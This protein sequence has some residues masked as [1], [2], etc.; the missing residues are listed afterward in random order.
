MAHFDNNSWLAEKNEIL[1]SLAAYHRRWNRTLVERAFDFSVQIHQ[2]QY[3]QSGEPYIT[4][5]IQVAKIMIELRTDYSAVAAALLHDVVE[6]G[7]VTIEELKERFG[8][9][10]ALLVD[11]VTKISGIEFQSS[12]E[13]QVES[14]RKMLLSMLKDLR[15]ILI[16]FA[17]RLHNMRTI[18]GKPLKSR[19]KV[20]RETRD[21]YAPLATR[22]GIAKIAREMDNL[23]LKVLDPVA[24]EEISYRISKTVER[25]NEILSEIIEPI[26][27]ELTRMGLHSDVQGRVKS[28]A[29]IYNK[30]HKQKKSFDEIYD[31]LAIR[32]IVNQ[33]SECYRVLGVVHDI[34]KPVTDHFSDYIALPKTNLYQS[35]H[36]KVRD[37]KNR[38]VEI[39]I[40]T[41]EMHNIAEIGIAAHWRYKA[42]H[43]QP[44]SLDEQFKWIRSIMEAHQESA[45]TGEF[46][47]SLKIDLFQD[48]IY[49]FTPQG[50]LIQLPKGATPIDFAFAIHSE[51]GLHAIGA[52]VKGRVVP[53]NYNLESGDIVQI[54]TSSNQKPNVEWFSFVR[55]SRARSHIK[56]WFKE[57]RWEQSK[58]L[59]EEMITRELNRLKLSNDESE[60]LEV[61]V[62]F[63]HL[64][65]SSFYAA[66]GSGIITLGQVMRKLVPIIAPKKDALISRIIQKIDRGKDRVR[67]SGLD[68]LVISIAECCSPLPG[69]PIIGFQVNGRGLF[70][71][72]TDCS[73]VAKLLEDETKVIPVAWDVDREDRFKTRIYVVADERVNLLRDITQIFSAVKVNIL[74]IE[75]FIE[76]RLVI[77]HITAEVKNLPHLTRLIGKINQ[78]KGILKVER[79][80][81]PEEITQKKSGKLL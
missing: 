58:S 49:I 35:L 57:T 21:V 11:G 70:I 24:Y 71:H 68:N 44:D 81:V 37:K 47:E 66:V 77:G 51:V 30:I 13:R 18:E 2:D 28:V 22:L 38:I 41:A 63:G 40:R 23:S 56:K 25:R 17:D 39:Q 69:D 14:L 61:A 31:L 65:L 54:L 55:T 16:K 20:A 36:T 42:G 32:I 8:E 34:Y 59:G 29:S 3:R 75:M 72:R 4:H 78:I 27:K 79:Q 53:L 48:E 33:K 67:V 62:S 6:D 50:K 7:E 46:L 9:Q 60:L 10:V 64:D 76:D 5:P 15:V 19:K 45:E 1:D 80:D 43:V 52:K 12:H 26:K 73:H 74:R